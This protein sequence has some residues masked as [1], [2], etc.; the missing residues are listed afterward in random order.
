[1]ANHR[2]T[3]EQFLKEAEAIYGD[4]KFIYLTRYETARTPIYIKC[5]QCGR[6]WSKIPNQHLQ[7]PHGCLSCSHFTE[8]CTEISPV[9]HE[10]LEGLIISDGSIYRQKLKG[11]LST[12]VF[13]VKNV[14]STF[15][16]FCEQNLPFEFARHIDAPKPFIMN[17]VVTGQCGAMD[18]IQS[19]SD[20]AL[21]SYWNRWYGGSPKHVPRDFVL[22]PRAARFWFY[23]DGSSSAYNDGKKVN[24][25]FCTNSFSQSDCEWLCSLWEQVGIAFYPATTP[26]GTVLT[27]GIT[28]HIHDFFDFMGEPEIE[29]FSYKWKRPVNIENT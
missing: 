2:K 22:T 9:Q 8:R 4:N 1:M 6:E 21:S 13:G 12:P 18:V 11:R 19:K 16:D 17:G 20:N 29:C 27:L 7:Q 3:H 15:V 26:T 24:I 14:Q 23:G 10:I 5:V 28:Q 25:R